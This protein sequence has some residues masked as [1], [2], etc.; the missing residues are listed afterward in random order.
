MKIELKRIKAKLYELSEHTFITN[1][2]PV[3]FNYHNEEALCDII[4]AAYFTEYNK[5]IG[6]HTNSSS[7]A[8]YIKDNYTKCLVSSEYADITVY[9]YHDV[10]YTDMFELPDG[11]RY[12]RKPLLN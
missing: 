9:S 1:L 11:S 8:V 5:F 10:L 2:G 3:V 4:A 12:L 6:F 7:D